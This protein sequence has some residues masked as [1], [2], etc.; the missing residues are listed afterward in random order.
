MQQ[1]TK[2]FALF[3]RFA[4]VRRLQTCSSFFNSFVNHCFLLIFFLT[5]Y[6]DAMCSAI[7]VSVSI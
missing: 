4:I 2:K 5:L 6:R 1:N 3:L 7:Q